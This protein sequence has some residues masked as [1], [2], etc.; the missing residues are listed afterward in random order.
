MD[1]GKNAMRV[2]SSRILSCHIQ[3]LGTGG[4]ELKPCVY[5]FTDSK[6]YLFNCVENVQRFS[7]EH[8]VRQG[9][10]RDFFITR[11]TWENVGG[12][13]GQAL[14]FSE[15]DE[16]QAKGP[17]CLHGPDS[18]EDFIHSSRF[19][20]AHKRISLV[21]GDTVETVGNHYLPVYRDENL[22]VRTLNLYSTTGAASRCPSSSESESQVTEPIVRGRQKRAKLTRDS[23]STSVFLCKLADVPGKFN[24]Q[25]AA[26]LGLPRG[27]QYA[28]LVK[29][30]SVTTPNGT[31]IHPSD[32]LGPTRIGPNLIVLECPDQGY[33][34]SLTT[35]PLLQKKWFDA[36][37]QRVSLIVHITPRAVLDS[38]EYCQW[39][40]SFGHE[41]KHLLLHE[42]VCPGEW[43]LRG[44]L[45]TRAPMHLVRPSLFREFSDSFA[46]VE[47]IES[48]KI[49]Q[50]LPRE[51]VIVGQ[52]L[53]KYHLKPSQ[54]VGVDES[55]TL[56][57]LASHWKRLVAEA[58]DNSDIKKALEKLPQ[59]L[60]S[61]SKSSLGKSAQAAKDSV[62]FLGTGASCPSKYRNVSGILLQTASAG[63]VLFDCG[64]G[65]LAQLYRHFGKC[66]GDK[67]LS[68]LRV[69][70][71]SHIHGDHNLGVISVLNKRADI[72]RGMAAESPLNEVVQTPTC[73]LGPSMVGWWLRDYSESCQKLPDHRFVNC[74]TLS[75]GETAVSLNSS[76]EFRT[77]PVIHCK[78]SYGVVVSHGKNWRVVYSGDTRPCPELV[79]AGKNATLLIHEATLEDALLEDAKEKKHCTVSE[80]LQIVEEMSPDFAILTHFSQRYIRVVPLLS[81]KAG[82]KSK[83]FTAFDHMTVDLSDLQSLPP[84]LPAVQEILASYIDEEDARMTWSWR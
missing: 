22:T 62:T 68:N 42:T 30:Q 32:V 8:K 53:L 66:E 1:D 37:E 36:S 48:L 46:E 38:E 12:L 11:M 67:I 70:F 75:E 69:V 13:A 60:E 23:N 49:L 14:H 39:M 15:F 45:K 55:H 44:F 4:G 19:H 73:V 71:I 34:P 9:K 10:L 40:T 28:E 50:S 25:K 65:T 7:N 58:R 56:E 41:T 2:V 21:A 79:A 59:D 31:V 54:K 16:A 84:L 35:H 78:G 51:C 80:A 20:M 24:P 72:L 17:V 33:V 26:E 6:R 74:G 82:L 61:K 76:L 3:V 63:N 18:L 57:P 43:T 77:V 64:E 29:G 81:N 5:L 83:V 47:S 52:P 27:P